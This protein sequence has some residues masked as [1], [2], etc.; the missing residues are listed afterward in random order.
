MK[1]FLYYI[2][3]ILLL[4]AVSCAPAKPPVP[5]GTIPHARSVT[6]GE[7]K[8]GHTVLTELSKQYPLEYND[9][10]INNVN[11]IVDRLAAAA[12]GQNEPWHVFLLNAPEV[13]N[14]AA[15][16]GNH[17]FVWTGIL[18]VTQNNDELAAVLAHEMAHLLAG[19]TDPDPNEQLKKILVGVGANVAGIAVSAV[20][21]KTG[22]GRVF[23]ELTSNI[24]GGL[25]NEALLNPYSRE[26]EF[27]ADHIGLMLMA[28]AGYNPEAAIKFWERM[29]SDPDLSSNLKYFTSHPTT[30]DRLG[31]LRTVLPKAQQFN[32]FTNIT[33]PGELPTNTNKTLI[34]PTDE[35]TSAPAQNSDWEVMKNQAKLYRAPRSDS[36]ILGEFKRGAKVQTGQEYDGWIEI[37]HPDHGFMQKH[38]LRP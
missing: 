15:T 27:E 4:F 8:Y 28:K 6:P 32:S 12:S 38:D 21:Y 2:C 16:R 25:G 9:P 24:T 33:D 29:R 23:G 35:I 1:S 3:L 17:I 19:H 10:R 30:E 26:K 20:S 37:I 13:K 36:R 7:E 14:A 18:D 11:A 31:A 34:T 22:F 5:V